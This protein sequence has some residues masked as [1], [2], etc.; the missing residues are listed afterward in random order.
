MPDCKP[1]ETY[2]LD[3]VVFSKG[4]NLHPALLADILRVAEEHKIDTQLSICPH[5]TWT[6]ADVLQISRAGVPTVLMELPLKYMH[7][8]VETCATGTIK[9]AARLLVAYI[10]SLGTDWRDKLLCD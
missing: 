2:P 3:K 1:D 4:P 6:D 8:T 10:A 9:E 5:V 7:T